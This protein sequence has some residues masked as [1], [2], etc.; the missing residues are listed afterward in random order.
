MLPP[1]VVWFLAL[2]RGKNFFLE[3]NENENTTYQLKNNFKNK[4]VFFFF[5]SGSQRKEDEMSVLG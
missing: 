3:L 5:K 2:V 1:Q 4:V